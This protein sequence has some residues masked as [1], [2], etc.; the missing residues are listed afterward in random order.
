MKL[1]ILDKD[2]KKT[3]ELTTE[4]F[5]EPIRIDIIRKVVEAERE[6]QP[7][8]TKLYAGMN[9]SAS[10]QVRHKRHSWKS[11]RGRGMSRIPKKQMWRRGT[12]FS[13]EGA[14]I[15]SARGGRRA[16]PPHGQLNN[17]KINKKEYR[18]ALLSSLSYISSADE[19]KKKYASLENKKFSLSLP[20]IFDAQLFSLKTKEF[21]HTLKNIFGEI[22]EVAIQKKNLRAGRGKT[23]GRKYK[24]SAGMLFVVGDNENKNINGVEIKK[25]KEI[26]VSDLAENGA[27]LTVF[28][29]EA[30]KEL[31]RKYLERKPEMKNK[32]NIEGM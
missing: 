11:D 20:L 30:I 23:R 13:W 15:P 4:L 12:Q 2:G 17:K 9:R 27:R 3:K 7:Y 19:V 26:K 10:G 16:H 21:L 32:N 14:I 8:S 25:A 29:E 18:K 28:T 24:K 6:W 31:E 5:E 1:H 22:A